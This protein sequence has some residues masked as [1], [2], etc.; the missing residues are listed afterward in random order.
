ME[1]LAG[2]GRGN[3]LDYW[4]G[5]AVN[6]DDYEKLR[7]L[8]REAGPEKLLF[9]AGAFPDH[10]DNGVSDLHGGVAEWA[11]D[12]RGSGVPFG[13]CAALPADPKSRPEPPAEFVGFRVVLDAGRP[14]AGPE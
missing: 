4:A 3:T 1:R 6:P 12:D 7:P 2:G 8:V 11:T 9:A 14:A 13:Q 5:Y 10:A